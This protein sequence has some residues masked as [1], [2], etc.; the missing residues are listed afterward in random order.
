[1]HKSWDSIW[2]PTRLS[3]GGWIAGARWGCLRT[4]Q[5]AGREPPGSHCVS[6]DTGYRNSQLVDR[7]ASAQSNTERKETINLFAL[8]VNLM[9]VNLRTPAYRLSPRTQE[10][11]I[12]STMSNQVGCCAVVSGAAAGSTDGCAAAVAPRAAAILAFSSST[13][14]RRKTL[15]TMV[16]GNSLRN[17]ISRGTL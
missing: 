9:H 17:S 10:P 13:N 3:S 5:G 2:I 16:L 11:S 4:K 14:T 7:Q 15:P 12:R 1:M 8:C 6:S